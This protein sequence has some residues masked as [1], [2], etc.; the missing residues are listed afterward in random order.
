[1]INSIITLGFASACLIHTLAY[2]Y[3]AY[4]T[5]DEEKAFKYKVFAD[6]SAILMLLAIALYKLGA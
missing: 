5:T 3:K 6:L 2:L 4:K 1:M